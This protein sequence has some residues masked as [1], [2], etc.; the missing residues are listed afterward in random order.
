MKFCRD[1]ENVFGNELE[2]CPACGSTNIGDVLFCQSCGTANEKGARYCRSCGEPM[3]GPVPQPQVA[4]KKGIADKV[5]ENEVVQAIKSDF[6]NSQT[7]ETLKKKKEKKK[8]KKEKPD[9]SI[10]AKKHNPAARM[11][12][13]I[14][15]IVLVAAAAIVVAVG[16]H[17]CDYCGNI[18][19]GER[20]EVNLW[21]DE[22][23]YVCD[24]CYDYVFGY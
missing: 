7:I 24:D 5:R 4:P 15:S 1:C 13:I 10:V 22:Y 19:F 3:N 17:E 18:Y 9:D 11:S 16:L 23:I 14:A 21:A 20:N 2:T 6:E 8:N 12:A